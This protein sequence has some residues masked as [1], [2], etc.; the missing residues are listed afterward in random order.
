MKIRLFYEVAPVPVE[1]V[2]PQCA[3]GAVHFD[4]TWAATGAALLSTRGG[5]HAA[6]HVLEQVDDDWARL[7]VEKGHDGWPSASEYVL[8]AA[9]VHAHEPGVARR[10]LENGLFAAGGQMF[11]DISTS[12][13]GALDARR[14][15]DALW[16]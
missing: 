1:W 3:A 6:R 2:R 9:L 16:S 15:V 5:P 7:R 10:R 13:L 12:P 11:V 8:Y 14:Y 4:A